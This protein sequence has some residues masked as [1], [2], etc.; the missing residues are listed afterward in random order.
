MKHI[1]ET[2]ENGVGYQFN[3][4]PT[5]LMACCDKNYRSLLWTLVQLSYMADKDGCFFRSM[6]DLRAQSFLGEKVVRACISTFH[7]SQ[8]K[9]DW[10]Y[11]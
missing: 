3:A 6:D 2:R 4:D 1:E 5:Y 9:V 10:F 8:D 7:R 11:L